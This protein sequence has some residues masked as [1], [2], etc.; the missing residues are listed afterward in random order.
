MRH[1]FFFFFYEKLDAQSDL[2]EERRGVDVLPLTTGET[3]RGSSSAVLSR[4]CFSVPCL[5]CGQKQEQLSDSCAAA[6]AV[7][8]AEAARE[9]KYARVCVRKWWADKRESRA[10]V[11]KK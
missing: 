3:K 9:S 2:E 10:Q 1:F 4:L 5:I 8:A 7:M 6:Y 11:K